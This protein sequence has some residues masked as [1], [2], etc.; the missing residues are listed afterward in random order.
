MHTIFTWSLQIL[1]MPQSRFISSGSKF[2][3]Y[4]TVLRMKCKFEKDPLNLQEIGYN[5]HVDKVL[6]KY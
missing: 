5:N 6:V 3:K 1:H 4:P 2:W